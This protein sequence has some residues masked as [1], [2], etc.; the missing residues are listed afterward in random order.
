MT[1][2][3]FKATGMGCAG[4]A[5]RIGTVLNEQPGV[6]EAS[7]SF[8]SGRATVEFDESR[9]STD[10]LVQAVKDAGYG[11]VPEEDEDEDDAEERE[12]KEHKALIIKVTA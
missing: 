4:C 5:A 10:S 11:L 2:K 6:K 7:V 12:R 1:R 3:N 8:V 9:C